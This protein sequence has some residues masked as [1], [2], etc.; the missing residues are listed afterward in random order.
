MSVKGDNPPTLSSSQQRSLRD[1][2]CPLSIQIRYSQRP[3]VLLQLDFKLA[4]S[5]SH[6]CPARGIE[7]AYYALRD[8]DS[9]FDG[10][11]VEVIDFD[12]IGGGI[13]RVL[14]RN[15]EAG[16]VDE[17]EARR[18]IARGGLLDHG[19]GVGGR[20]VVLDLELACLLLTV[21]ANWVSV[22]ADLRCLGK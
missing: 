13:G 3:L 5:F 1:Q 8:I 12:G 20:A 7:L 6:E 17:K 21:S 14:S 18:R 19:D 10:C 9:G 2:H 4:E 11:A 16:R 22:V 15:H